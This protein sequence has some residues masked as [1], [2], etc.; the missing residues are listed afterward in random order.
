[1]IAQV[2]ETRRVLFLSDLGTP[3]SAGFTE[4]ET[5]VFTGVQTP[6]YKIEFYSESLEV[7][8]FP[9]DVSR[10]EF[11][12]KLLRRY[13]EHKPDVI[14]A[15]G[16]ASLKFIAELHERV[17]PDTPVIFCGCQGE[18]PQ[19]RI[20]IRLHLSHRLDHARAAR[21]TE[22]PAEQYDR[23]LHFNYTRCRRGAFH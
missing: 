12:E 11:S 19:L 18:L 14:V 3:A 23:L 8:L 15:A 1:M 22:A 16:S 17:F 13:S 2:N 10:Q 21:T 9:G 20:E 6:P 4:I 5:A 7:T